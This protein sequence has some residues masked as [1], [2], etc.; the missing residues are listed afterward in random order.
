MSALVCFLVG[1]ATVLAFAPFELHPLA[2][3]SFAFL[4]HQW[5]SAPPRRC[6]WLGFWFGLGLYGAGVSW[7]YVSLHQFGGMPAPL[8]GFATV[9][10]CAFLALFPAAAGWLQARVPAPDAVRACL[11]VPAAWVLFEWLLVWIFTGFPWLALGYTAAGWPL[12]GYA[13]LGGVYALSFITVSIAGMLWLIAHRRPVFVLVAILAIGA[14]E[15]L[16]HVPWSTPAGEPVSVALLQ[17]NIE[18][19]MKFRPERYARIQETYAQLAEGTAARLIVFPETALPRFYH[20]VDP[21]YL[22]R[23]EAAAKRNGGDLLLGAPYLGGPEAYFNSVLTLGVSPRQAYHKVHL[24]PFGEFIPPGFGWVLRWLS[25]PL[26][27][28][29]RGAPDQPPLAVAGQRVAVNVC[30]EDVFGD[31]IARRAPAATLLVNVSNVAWFGDSLAPAQHLQIAR[32]RAIETA[33]MHLTATNTGITAAID[34][35][36]RV[37]KRL[38]QFTEGRLEIA[39]QGYSGA[40]PYVRLRDWPI[41]LLSVFIF[42]AFIVRARRSR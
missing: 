15:A 17:G 18:Q 24:V 29:S 4:I 32:L 7:V 23:L 19:E 35:D 12:Q 39:A 40:T 5:V 11:L 1:A 27:D 26:S 10:Y 36:G 25:I 42:I 30:Y 21:A 37:L 22:A 8:A 14:G 28:F 34:R 41:V 20:Q 33:R 3:L 31:E 9:A 2:F 13:P 16:R 6:L 38:A